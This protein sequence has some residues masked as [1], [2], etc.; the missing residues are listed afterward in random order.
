MPRPTEVVSVR[1]PLTGIHTAL[2]P[3]VDYAEDHELVVAYPWAFVPREVTDEIVESVA[4]PVVEQ[5]TA[6]PGEKRSR[7][8]T[9]Q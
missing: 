6:A 1:H 8:R 3:A 7:T 2:N 9:R 5:A 4:V